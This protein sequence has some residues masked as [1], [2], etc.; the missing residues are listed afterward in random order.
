MVQSRND[1]PEL[2]LLDPLVL[3]QVSIRI[4]GRHGIIMLGKNVQLIISS[5]GE[6][7]ASAEVIRRVS[8]SRDRHIRLGIIGR[9]RIIGG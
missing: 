9:G 6:I 1:I 3:G 2:P 5:F 7:R 8:I 4:E